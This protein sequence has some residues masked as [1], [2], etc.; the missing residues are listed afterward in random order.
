M[1]FL[2]FFTDTFR[3]KLISS[4]FSSQ[5]KKLSFSSTISL[6]F[7]ELCTVVFGILL[8][9]YIDRW[10]SSQNIEQQFESTLKIIQKHLESDIYNS[11]NVIAHYYSRD[12]LRHDIMNFIRTKN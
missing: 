2:K 1:P 12:S 6:V 8:V 9:L 4:K 10:N 5:D 3:L 7:I 11:D